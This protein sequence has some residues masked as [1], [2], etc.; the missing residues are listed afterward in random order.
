MAAAWL[1]RAASAL[2]RKGSSAF[3][4]RARQAA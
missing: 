2:F 1:R 4:K 3:S